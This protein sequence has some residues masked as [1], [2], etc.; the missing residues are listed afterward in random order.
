MKPKRANPAPRPSAEHDKHGW[1]SAATRWGPCRRRGWRRHRAAR[2]FGLDVAAASRNEQVVVR[3]ARQSSS[4]SWTAR[5]RSAV[6]GGRGEIIPRGW[7][8]GTSPRV[9]LPQSRAG[10]SGHAAP[11]RARPDHS[12]STLS[13]P[14]EFPS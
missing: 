10:S 11:R 7:P 6:P 13:S 2:F 3:G 9:A 12:L 1:V 8:A 5:R 4:N 14:E